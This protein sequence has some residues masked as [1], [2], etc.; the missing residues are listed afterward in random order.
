[1]SHRINERNSGNWSIDGEP[2]KRKSKKLNPDE[3]YLA[4][5]ILGKVFTCMDYDK[6]L[7]AYTD[8]GN[9]ILSLSKEEMETLAGI[10][11]K[12]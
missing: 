6:E 7:E 4:N 10:I 3:Q 11:R 12:F 9:F 5:E 2:K 1:M 8:G